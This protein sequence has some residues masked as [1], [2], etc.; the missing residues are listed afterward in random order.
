MQA[1]SD[2]N[3]PHT[4]PA[5]AEEKERPHLLLAVLAGLF[6]LG[7]LVSAALALYWFSLA[8][9]AQDALRKLQGQRQPEAGT[10]LAEVVAK[11]AVLGAESWAYRY[12]CLAL[13]LGYPTLLLGRLAFSAAERARWARRVRAPR[14]QVQ[15]A[16]EAAGQAQRAPLDIAQLPKF[17]PGN[18]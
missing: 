16:A 17:P 7:A 12:L 6:V 5:P 11:A 4:Q 14:R 1:T 9:Q 8:W 18:R 3:E 15:P 13:L 10:V 2:H